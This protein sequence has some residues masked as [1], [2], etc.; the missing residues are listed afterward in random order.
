LLNQWFGFG[1]ETPIRFPVFAGVFLEMKP[2][3]V[4]GKTHA[5]FG[6]IPE[7]LCPANPD[8]FVGIGRSALSSEI[9]KDYRFVGYFFQIHR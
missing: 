6:E 2:D 9:G 7:T 1:P 8:R 4:F 3:G 5:F